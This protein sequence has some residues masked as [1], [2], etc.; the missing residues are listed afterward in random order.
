MSATAALF[1][2]LPFSLSSFFFSRLCC[3]PSVIASLL[4]PA[5]GLVGA[6]QPPEV[7]F[8]TLAHRFSSLSSFFPFLSDGDVVERNWYLQ[9]VMQATDRNAFWE[10]FFV[11]DI[12]RVMN[13][14]SDKL[15]RGA[16]MWNRLKELY[17]TGVGEI[18]L[19][20]RGRPV[21]VVSSQVLSGSWF[22]TAVASEYLGITRS[23]W[24]GG[25]KMV[26]LEQMRASPHPTS[27]V[28]ACRSKSS[29]KELTIL[30]NSL[31]LATDKLARVDHRRLGV[32]FHKVAIS[33]MHSL[34]PTLRSEEHQ[35]Y[36][37]TYPMERIPLSS[38]FGGMLQ[39]DNILSTGELKTGFELGGAQVRRLRDLVAVVIDACQPQYKAMAAATTGNEES[40]IRPIVISAYVYLSK[41]VD[42][43]EKVYWNDSV[44]NSPKSRL[45]ALCMHALKF[46][47]L[48]YNTL[49]KQFCLNGVR[50]DK[51]ARYLYQAGQPPVIVSRESALSTA[52][53]SQL[54]DVA[55]LYAKDFVKSSAGRNHYPSDFC[56]NAQLFLVHAAIEQFTAAK[57]SLDAKHDGGKMGTRNFHNIRHSPQ[58]GISVPLESWPACREFFHLPKEVLLE[59]G[60][61]GNGVYRILVDLDQTSHLSGVVT[62]NYDFASAHPRLKLDIPFTKRICEPGQRPPGPFYSDLRAGDTFVRPGVLYFTRWSKTDNAHKAAGEYQAIHALDENVVSSCLNTSVD[63]SI[64]SEGVAAGDGENLMKL[65]ISRRILVPRIEKGLEQIDILRSQRDN[66]RNGRPAGFASTQLPVFLQKAKKSESD[67]ND[68]LH[69][70]L[71]DIVGPRLVTDYLNG[72]LSDAATSILLQP[73]VHDSMGGSEFQEVL[74]R[75]AKLDDDMAV[76][77]GDVQQH[78]AIR[79]ELVRD[80]I[81]ELKP[82]RARIRALDETKQREADRFNTKCLQS[83]GGTGVAPRTSKVR[84]SRQPGAGRRKI[85]LEKESTLGNGSGEAGAE[86]ELKK[87]CTSLGPEQGRRK[88]ELESESE[89]ASESEIEN[90]R[91]RLRMSK[92]QYAK[93]KKQRANRLRAVGRERKKQNPNSRRQLE[94]NSFMGNSF[95]ARSTRKKISL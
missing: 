1:R 90:E 20:A 19:R 72:D 27:L 16:G 94:L 45:R 74:D 21:W 35:Y 46:L 14:R 12:D 36:P 9:S 11:H 23:S 75:Y 26:A 64:R 67:L 81:E 78:F 92:R 88:D 34:R 70:L 80:C 50:V 73:Y 18:K 30:R 95:Y 6:L 56:H 77:T 85:E 31:L 41:L 51:K 86:P 42:A 24:T 49:L 3:L 28:L 68:T 43:G 57:K 60:K 48:I 93:L 44:D 71:D 87:S 89:L 82:V 37:T 59:Q 8:F 62:L 55:L 33:M 38:K 66:M 22:K 7:L 10:A 53:T 2:F 58:F 63:V 32:Y 4:R 13:F 15:I 83:L 91:Q 69:S 65:E 25:T 54:S 84:A 76:E 52:E 79:R 17:A 61:N 39:F 40:R 5:E 29:G 47:N